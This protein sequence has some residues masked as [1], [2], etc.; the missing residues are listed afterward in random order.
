MPGPWKTIE[1][2]ND[3]VNSVPLFHEVLRT[4]QAASP[5]LRRLTLCVG[6]I[7]SEDDEYNG[8]MGFIQ[9]LDIQPF[10]QFRNLTS[11]VLVGQ[12]TFPASIDSLVSTLLASPKLTIL[13]LDLEGVPL[14]RVCNAYADSGGQPFA[15][16][17]LRFSVFK[18]RFRNGW[19]SLR[20]LATFQKLQS[21]EL[22]IGYSWDDK[23][24]YTP[25]SREPIYQAIADPAKF[26]SL[27]CLSVNRLDDS[28]LTVIRKVG[29][30][31]DFPPFFLSE[32]F[33]E[34]FDWDSA[35]KKGGFSIHPEKRLYW[36][37]CFVL[38]QNIGYPSTSE[39]RLGL[40]REISGW[41]GLQ[42]LHLSLD[43]EK[44]RV[45]VV[46]RVII[47][48]RVYMWFALLTP[49]TSLAKD[50][51]SYAYRLALYQ[52]FRIIHHERA[53]PPWRE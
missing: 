41:Q 37:T 29:Q 48:C 31:P 33:F 28:L 42:L 40:V 21:V 16:R 23:D 22:D 26:T 45:C 51:S 50:P 30:S 38:G 6:S 9:D 15:L 36:P 17:H 52:P 8:W 27:R 47:T 46:I 7:P 44:D 39:F 35:I 25:A 32:L 13:S 24:T 11:L 43:M 14:S 53:L 20:K 19:S 2:E 18:E 3:G 4:L 10:V 49:S 34:V 1:E 12:F 5:K